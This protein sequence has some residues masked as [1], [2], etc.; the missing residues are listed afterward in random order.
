[1]RTLFM[2]VFALFMCEIAQAQDGKAKQILDE[3]SE[4]TKSFKSIS[5]DF[6]FSLV[7]NELEMD[8]KNEGSIIMKGQKYRVEL[9]DLGLQVYSDGETLWNYMAEGNQVTINAID[10]E[11]S[12]LMDPSTLFSIY[13]KG[14]DSKFISETK[15]GAKSILQIELL[16]NN[17]EYEV[18]KIVVSIDKNSMLLHAAVLYSSD[19]N[20][21]GI[22]VKKMDTT[23]VFPDS[24]FI[25]NPKNF[26]DIEVI[27]F[28]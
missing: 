15:I 16:P 22:E 9:K 28:R 10:N 4:K 5:A 6:T 12:D 18:S 7:N 19:G 21:Y 26:P 11:S 24:E 20:Q 13:E 23:K 17:E 25:F 3:V 14:F 1:M 27:D 8:E 2:L